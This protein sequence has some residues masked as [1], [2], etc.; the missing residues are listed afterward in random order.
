MLAMAR[1]QA[2]GNKEPKEPR[3]KMRAR[4]AA[5]LENHKHARNVAY[6]F[7]ALFVAICIG[8]IYRVYSLPPLPPREIRAHPMGSGMPNVIDPSNIVRNMNTGDDAGDGAEDDGEDD[9]EDE[10]RD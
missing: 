1:K 2:S 10:D 8:V 7:L 3:E 5:N 9:G 4:K 6:G